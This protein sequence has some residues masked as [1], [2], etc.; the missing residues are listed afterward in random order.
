MG[1]GAFGISRLRGPGTNCLELEIL[2]AKV[3]VESAHGKLSF[4]CKGGDRSDS[5]S[6]PGTQSW[7]CTWKRY[8]RKR[9]VPGWI[10]RWME[11][12]V[13][14]EVGTLVDE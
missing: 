4:L 6:S 10:D 13:G 5:P 1:L 12:W 3:T 7:A 8:S 2:S 9:Q 11:P 14:R